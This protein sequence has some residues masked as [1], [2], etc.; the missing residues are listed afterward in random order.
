MTTLA[1]IIAA[2]AFAALIGLCLALDKSRHEH[3]RNWK[4]ERANAAWWRA[5]AAEH[6]KGEV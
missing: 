3:Y 4:D 1:H 6:G 2:V 5:L